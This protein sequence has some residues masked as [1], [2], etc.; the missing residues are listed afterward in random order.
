[1]D[2]TYDG[3]NYGHG[4]SRNPAEPRGYKKIV[5]LVDTGANRLTLPL[6]WKGQLG[7]FKME[8]TIE[9]QLAT[10]EVVTGIIYGPAKIRVGRVSGDLQQSDFSGYEA[11]EGRV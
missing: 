3:K 1:M 4:G 8:K 6:A 11:G 5:A 7:S 10:D 2:N 9:L